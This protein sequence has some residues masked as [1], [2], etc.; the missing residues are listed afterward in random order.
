MFNKITGIVKIIFGLLFLIADIVIILQ[1]MD[2]SN[3]IAQTV[4]MITG[5][6]ILFL[7]S[8]YLI[9]SGWTLIKDINMILAVVHTGLVTLGLISLIF[10]ITLLARNTAVPKAMSIFILLVTIFAGLQDWIRIRR[11]K[12]NP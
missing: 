8:V 2:L 11:Q 3:D 6:I 9:Y 12:K 4:G 1:D 7:F 10:F 5:A